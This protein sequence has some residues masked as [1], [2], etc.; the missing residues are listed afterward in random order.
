[1]RLHPIALLSLLALCVACPKEGETETTAPET[2]APA[3]E[4]PEKTAPAASPAPVPSSPVV[5]AWSSDSTGEIFDFS[6]D[7]QVRIRKIKADGA[8]A[9][10]RHGPYTFIGGRFIEFTPEG[11]G[12]PTYKCELASGSITCELGDEGAPF[13]LEKKV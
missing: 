5:G 1:M 9:E 2:A 10:P 11:E 13:K 6:N 7:G 3:A 4:G 8:E 12:A